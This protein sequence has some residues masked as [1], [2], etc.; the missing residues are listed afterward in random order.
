[1]KRL[2]VFCGSSVGSNPAYAEA[3]VTLGTLLARRGIGLVYGGGN[4]GLMGVIADAALAAGGEVIGV[5]PK[6]LADR[7]VAHHGVTELRVVDSMHTRKAMMADLSDAFIAMPGGVGTF[8]EF[9]EAITWTQL[10]LHRKACGLLNV[11]GFYTPLAVFIDQAVSDG[12]IKPVHRAAIVVDDNPERLLDTLTTI[13]LPDAP[14]WSN[15]R[16]T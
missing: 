2:C 13:D 6:A 8:E 15:R 4:V 11:A 5:I 10:G 16:E 12:F 9:F 1:M 3:A 7:E 14:K